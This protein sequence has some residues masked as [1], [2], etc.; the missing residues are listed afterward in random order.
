MTKYT[1]WM[2][3]STVANTIEWSYNRS[4]FSL[5]NFYDL[6]VLTVGTD[7]QSLK[8]KQKNCNNAMVRLI[9]EQMPLLPLS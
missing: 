4:Y 2:L 6:E 9:N 7:V 8:F 1:D 3:Q 5:A